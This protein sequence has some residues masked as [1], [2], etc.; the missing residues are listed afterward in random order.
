MSSGLYS[1]RPRRAW[2][3]SV[4]PKNKSCRILL[5]TIQK[6]AKERSCPLSIYPSG[7]IN[8]FILIAAPLILRQGSNVSISMWRSGEIIAVRETASLRS[9]KNS[10]QIHV[11]LYRKSS[12]CLRGLLR[13]S[14]SATP[15]RGAKHVKGREFQAQSLRAHAV[16]T[17][18]AYNPVKGRSGTRR[19]LRLKLSTT[20]GIEEKP[21]RA[22]VP[23]AEKPQSRRFPFDV[24]FRKSYVCLSDWSLDKDPQTPT[25][26]TLRETRMSCVIS[27][28]NPIGNNHIGK[29]QIPT[30]AVKETPAVYTP[31]AETGSLVIREDESARERNYLLEYPYTENTLYAQV[32]PL[33]SRNPGA[34]C[35]HAH[36]GFMRLKMNSGT[37]ANSNQ[38][39][40]RL[41]EM[42]G[43]SEG[44]IG[45]M[46]VTS[47]LRR[48][49]L[50][51]LKYCELSGNNQ[52]KLSWFS[53]SPPTSHNGAPRSA[54][55]S[56]SEVAGGNNAR[57]TDS[58]PIGSR[59]G[60]LLRPLHPSFGSRFRRPLLARAHCPHQN[61][62][63]RPG[64]WV[65][66]QLLDTFM[67]SFLRGTIPLNDPG[68]KMNVVWIFSPGDT[69][70]ERLPPHGSLGQSYLVIKLC[71]GC[72]LI[73]LFIC[74]RD[75]AP[76]EPIISHHKVSCA[77]SRIPRRLIHADLPNIAPPELSLGGLSL[78]NPVRPPVSPP[79]PTT[80]DVAPG[81]PHSSSF[82][83]LSPGSQSFQP[84]TTTYTK[85]LTNRL[86][87]LTSRGQPRR[88][89]VFQP[90]QL[91]SLVHHP[92]AGARCSAAPGASADSAFDL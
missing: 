66:T 72:K 90:P 80:D 4:L 8:D 65:T 18:Y 89:D 67:D 14:D 85:T 6:Y 64:S 22:E 74:L 28:T 57:G 23:Q 31:S 25:A 40:G 92:Y 32:K 42:E 24:P 27:L 7:L 52:L 86:I 46:S 13:I 78:F 19:H 26:Q 82:R 50:V 88:Q 53:R 30:V 61:N 37:H 38:P 3:A 5:M 75:P 59:A 63:G 84:K 68:S 62:W 51:N 36:A 35:R 9:S 17:T 10:A 16:R 77:L 44:A 34:S 49:G 70:L 45:G 20:V 15:G 39:S 55:E 2:S 79:L 43:G 29:D 12:T 41:A 73:C 47:L 56:A 11:G 83:R 58:E 54:E 1:S 60:G 21:A 33:S 48:H 76:G 71:P 91:V 69:K 81:G 87:A